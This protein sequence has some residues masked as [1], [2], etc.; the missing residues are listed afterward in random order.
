[1]M[2]L[3]VEDFQNLSEQSEAVGIYSNFCNL[4]ITEVI[5]I[6]KT[7]IMLLLPYLV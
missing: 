6:R 5:Q 7:D 2:L 3:C 4:K 1:M